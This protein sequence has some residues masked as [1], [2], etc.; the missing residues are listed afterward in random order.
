MTRP[1]LILFAKA[2]VAGRV[3]TRLCPPLSADEAAALHT[4]FVRDTAALLTSF[5]ESADLELSSDTATAEWPDLQ[6]PRSVQT[7]GDLGARLLHSIEG[8]LRSGRGQAI[9]FGSD[10]PGLPP[11]HVAWLLESGADVSF[12]PTG[13]GG[14]FAI[15]CRKTSPNMFAGV[16][17]STGQTLR[18]AMDAAARCGLSAAAGPPWFDVDVEQD[19]HDLLARTDLPAHTAR[20]ARDR[21]TT[22]NHASTL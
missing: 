14:F 12:G 11:G 13:D 17:W 20:W 10:S 5:A 15:A 6:L 16:R 3:K 21:E 4:A 22:S 2:P 7:E 18:D 1:I 9:V 19:L 8:A